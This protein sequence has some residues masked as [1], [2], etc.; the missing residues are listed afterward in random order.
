MLELARWAEQQGWFG[1]WVAD[2]YMPN[3][4]TEDVADGP[5]NECWSYLAAL[6]ATTT[7]LRIGPLV[8]PTTVHHPA[9]LANRAATI[10]LISNGRF[11]LG[12]G[13]GWQINEHRAYGI[14]LLAPGDRVTRFGEAI[15]IVR[16]LLDRPRT[17]F[18][19]SHFQIVDAP[20]EPKPVGEVPIVVG[21]AGPR[22]LGIVA[23]F[24]QEW[25][26]WGNPQ[27]VAT[28][29]E[30]LEAALA[31]AGRDP[32][33]MHRSAQAMIV[34]TDDTVTQ[35]DGVNPGFAER[36]IAGTPEQIAEQ[37]TGYASLGV[38]EFIVPDFWELDDLARKR[39][40]YDR[41]AAEV[42]PL[43]G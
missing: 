37:I 6:A 42:V 38:G 19:G 11:V 31:K 26:C 27:L 32:S 43:V 17:T 16:S 34:F 23:R 33:T 8:A 12:L 15:E 18:A 2:H 24:A 22:M 4:G 20:C 39:H 25:N 36:T 41:F 10:D 29:R 7:S 14:D 28:R 40:L 3:T 5:F 13:A 21:S 9:L 35:P 30:P 1:A